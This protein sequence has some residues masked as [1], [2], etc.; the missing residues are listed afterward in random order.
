MGKS[1]RTEGT[2]S[3]SDHRKVVKV[4]SIPTKE[5]RKRESREEE[6]FKNWYITK[7]GSRGSHIIA[8]GAVRCTKMDGGFVQVSAKGSKRK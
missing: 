3:N 5:G 2:D 4:K 1:D 8:P 6:Q 7:K